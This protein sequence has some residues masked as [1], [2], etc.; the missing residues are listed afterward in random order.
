M[1]LAISFNVVGYV[2]VEVCTQAVLAATTDRGTLA[3]CEP[4]AAY[5]RQAG[6][7]GRRLVPGAKHSTALWSECEACA[8]GTVCTGCLRASC[9]YYDLGLVEIQAGVGSP[10]SG[11]G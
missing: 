7:T 5:D 3:T 11:N 9:P 2:R 4:P 8:K 1:Y 6:G 10:S